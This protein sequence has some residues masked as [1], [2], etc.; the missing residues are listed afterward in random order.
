[1]TRGARTCANDSAPIALRRKKEAHGGL[2]T[3]A[4]HRF[5]SAATQPSG[6]PRL[7]SASAASSATTLPSRMRVP[8]LL[9]HV[10]AV[11]VASA[12]SA[13]LAAGDLWNDKLSCR[14]PHDGPQSAAECR[15]A[16]A[17][18]QSECVAWSYVVDDEKQVCFFK[19][20]GGCERVANPKER[21]SN[22]AAVSVLLPNKKHNTNN[23]VAGAAV[24]GAN[25]GGGGGGGGDDNDDDDEKRAARSDVAA[26]PGAPHSPR[27][28]KNVLFIV[29]DDMRPNIGAYN[30]SFA[31]TPNMDALAAEGLRFDRAYVRRRHTKA[32]AH[33]L[34]GAVVIAPS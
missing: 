11:A 21:H 20:S 32:P 9:N 16:C 22:G 28:R 31:H 6:L 2:M 19:P 15:A 7:G 18:Q 26:T 33:C 17:A 12:F 8:P 30:Y 3:C 29:V 25:S 24:D 1:V 5:A 4:L 27:G 34:V 14:Q 10:L 23:T 13:E